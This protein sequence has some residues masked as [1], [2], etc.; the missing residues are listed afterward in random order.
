[1]GR[2]GALPP[3][4]LGPLVRHAHPRSGTARYVYTLRVELEQNGQRFQE[5]RRVPLVAGE[6]VEVDFNTIA[7]TRTVQN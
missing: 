1:M 3:R 4:R 5:S 2:P 7:A 6:R